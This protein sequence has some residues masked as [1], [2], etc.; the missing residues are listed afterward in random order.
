[1]EEGSKLLQIQYKGEMLVMERI[2]GKDLG[3][4]GEEVYEAFEDAV[5]TVLEDS[6]V[7][8]DIHMDATLNDEGLFCWFFVV[9]PSSDA[10][11][12][13]WDTDIR[14]RALYRNSWADLL[15][16]GL[17]EKYGSLDD[18]G[19]FTG[20]FVTE[21]AVVFVFLNQAEV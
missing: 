20:H 5:F 16:R 8:I 4:F 13:E 15:W 14:D 3:K 11:I 9:R 7:D 18:R 6:P 10:D 1:M 21:T 2:Y 12:Q 19:F 17:N